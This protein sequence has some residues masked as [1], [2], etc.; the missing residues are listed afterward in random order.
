MV[1][2]M[3]HSVS[4]WALPV[5]IVALLLYAATKKVKVYEHFVSGAMDGLRT[6]VYIAPYLIAMFVALGILRSSGL[7]DTVLAGLGPITERVGIPRDVLPLALLRPL[8]GTGALGVMV[9]L[10]EQHGPDSFVGRLASTMQGST[11]TT[12]YVLTV[13]AGAA[14]IK[15]T[16]HVLFTG[17]TADATAFVAAALFVY[18]LLGR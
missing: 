15:R 16:R 1:V 6:T 13:Y 17:L 2:S 14:N 12:L 5:I 18:V 9:E 4:Q 8:S 3:L 7:L 10:L 11:E